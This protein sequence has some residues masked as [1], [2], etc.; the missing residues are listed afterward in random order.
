MTH[1]RENFERV[2]AL[3]QNVA[4]SHLICEIS[5]EEVDYFNQEGKLALGLSQFKRTSDAFQRGVPFSKSCNF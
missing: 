4:P 5:D 3:T 2:Y 1:H